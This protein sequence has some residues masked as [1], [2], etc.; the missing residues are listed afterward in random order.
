MKNAILVFSST[1]MVSF[2]ILCYV[3]IGHA[4]ADADD[5]R[6]EQRCPGHRHGPVWMSSG[7]R[8]GITMS[9]WPFAVPYLA[10]DMLVD[11]PRVCDRFD[12]GDVGSI[13][14]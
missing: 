14:R 9:L 11:T 4:I 6:F 5:L 8:R 13:D 2:F 3:G 7:F 12:L 1:F 10:I